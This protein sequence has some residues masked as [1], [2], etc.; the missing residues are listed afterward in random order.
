MLVSFDPAVLRAARE[1][2]KH[3]RICRRSA[4]AYLGT[5]CFFVFQIPCWLQRSPL[6]RK[7]R[8]APNKPCSGAGKQPR[9]TRT[10]RRRRSRNMILL[11]RQS[12][13]E[14]EKQ[15]RTESSV[16]GVVVATSWPL[17]VSQAQVVR[18]LAVALPRVISDSLRQGVGASVDSGTDRE[19]SR[20]FR[21]KGKPKKN[22]RHSQPPDAQR[23]S[24]DQ[25]AHPPRAKSC[26]IGGLASTSCR[27]GR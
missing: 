14:I 8:T 26:S 15:K 6:R 2:D 10:N 17:L 4:T 5:P 12:C 27:S 16:S 3:Q 7:P 11:H 19:R 25:A 18:E 13:A 24:R 20:V 22:L 1:E 9:S 23:T 21:D